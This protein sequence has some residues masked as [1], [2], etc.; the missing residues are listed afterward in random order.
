MTMKNKAPAISIAI[1][2]T[3]LGMHGGNKKEPTSC[4]DL[5]MKSKPKGKKPARGKARGC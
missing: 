5:D 1:M 3:K 2:P 4:D